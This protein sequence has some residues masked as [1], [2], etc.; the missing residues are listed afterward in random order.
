MRIRWIRNTDSRAVENEEMTLVWLC[1]QDPPGPGPLQHQLRGDPPHRPL[2]LR[3]HL[4]GSA[5][6]ISQPTK[7]FESLIKISF[8]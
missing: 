4:S 6:H 2:P 3:H 1:I 5:C 7:T 8:E